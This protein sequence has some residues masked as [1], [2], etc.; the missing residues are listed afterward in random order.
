[1]PE[2]EELTQYHGMREQSKI[3][4]GIA[5]LGAAAV[6]GPLGLLA[7]YGVAVLGK[8]AHKSDV[9]AVVASY[10]NDQEVATGLNQTFE[11]DMEFDRQLYNDPR[12]TDIDRRQHE[13]IAQRYA[14]ELSV[15]ENSLDPAVRNKALDAMKNITDQRDA[16]LQDIETRARLTEDEGQKREWALEDQLSANERALYQQSLQFQHAERLQ[17]EK[18]RIQTERGLLMDNLTTLREAYRGKSAAIRSTDTFGSIIQQEHYI[19]SGRKVL[20]RAGRSAAE[21][22]INIR[23]QQG[24]LAEAAAAAAAGARGSEVAALVASL[25]KLAGTA[26]AYLMGENLSDADLMAL[27][28]GLDRSGEAHFDN[29]IESAQPAV[30]AQAERAGANPDSATAGV[31]FELSE[32]QQEWRDQRRE[33]W[34]TDRNRVNRGKRV[35]GLGI[36]PA[37]TDDDLYNPSDVQYDRLRR[38]EERAAERAESRAIITPNGPVIIR[39]RRVE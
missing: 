11:S 25:G 16:W 13:M 6:F 9:D 12:V 33:G 27:A 8:R 7:G 3:A 20:T 30:R 29:I 2:R 39:Q 19:E 24:P 22:H 34:D 23:M 10:V 37:A 35:E 17:A 15:F 36:N 4:G 1:M 18:E 21:Q 5:G 31:S 32:E 28:E 26:S 38:A 14:R